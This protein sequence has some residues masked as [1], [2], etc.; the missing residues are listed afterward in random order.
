MDKWL[1][2]SKL[3][4]TAMLA[5][6]SGQITE[7]VVQPLSLREILTQLSQLQALDPIVSAEILAALGGGRTGI[8]GAFSYGQILSGVY[9]QTG[10][11]LRASWDFES[12]QVRFSRD[13]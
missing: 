7:Q 6:Y 11:L 4:G 3:P 10:Q 9:A 13:S 12:S 8:T 1:I 5:S 2:Q